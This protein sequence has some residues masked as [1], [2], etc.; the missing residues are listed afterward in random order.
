MVDYGIW[1]KAEVKKRKKPSFKV[2]QISFENFIVS[3]KTANK[4]LYPLIYVTLFFKLKTNFP[5]VAA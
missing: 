1:I 5:S 4:I 2:K 3:K